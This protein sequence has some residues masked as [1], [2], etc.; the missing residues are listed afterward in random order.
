MKMLSAVLFIV[1]L[2]AFSA[3]GGDNNPVGPSPSPQPLPS[4]SVAVSPGSA[5]MKVGNSLVLTA[6]GGDG[7]YSWETD[8]ILFLDVR[9]LTSNRSQIEITL[10]WLPS[11]I[12]TGKVVVY[13]NYSS[14]EVNLT[15]RP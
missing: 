8:G 3:C 11:G 2:S 6:S 5:T 10:D 4:T 13:S 14:A 15:Y 7:Y 1:F 12:T 9:P